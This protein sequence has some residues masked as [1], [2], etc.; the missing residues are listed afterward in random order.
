MR[1]SGAEGGPA[2]EGGHDDGATRRPECP[3]RARRRKK[4]MAASVEAEAEVGG[5]C[6]GGARAGRVDRARRR[7]PRGP[8][9]PNASAPCSAAKG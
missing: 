1:D 9:W 4:K 8:A 6:G 5:S 2:L 3:R 7:R